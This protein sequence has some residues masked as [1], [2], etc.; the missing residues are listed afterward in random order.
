[1]NWSI[2]FSKEKVWCENWRQISK[3][4]FKIFFALLCFLDSLLLPWQSWTPFFK[5]GFCQSLLSQC[6][7]GGKFAKLAILR[8]CTRIE[9]FRAPY[10]IF[11]NVVSGCESSGHWFIEMVN[12]AETTTGTRFLNASS[13]YSNSIQQLWSPIFLVKLLITFALFLI[14]ADFGLLYIILASK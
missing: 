10:L 7:L 9:K 2:P 1:M 3:E 4:M 13:A 11:W 5:N 6:F 8:Y 12:L 14:V